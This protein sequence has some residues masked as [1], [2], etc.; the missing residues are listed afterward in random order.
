MDNTTLII[1]FS[2]NFGLFSWAIRARTW[3]KYSHVDIV[4]DHKTYLGAI[5]SRG[6]CIHE[7]EYPLQDFFE[8]EVTPLQYDKILLNA[9]SQLGKPYDFA[10]IFGFA[11][12]RDWQE[13]DKWFCS[14]FIAA[15]IQPIVPLF[16]EEAFKI[17]PRDL[18]IHTKFKKIE[19]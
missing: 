2:S 9:V 7:E 13:D 12:D 11:I 1:R 15:S 10:G 17:S 4:L 5:P 3:S 8:V 16:N 14:E 19:K 6:V 18:S